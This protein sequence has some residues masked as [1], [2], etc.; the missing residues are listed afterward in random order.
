MA[1]SS[2]T[3]S[4]IEKTVAEVLEAALPGLRQQMAARVAEAFESAGSDGSSPTALLSAAATAIQEAGSQAEILRQLL[5]GSS[6]FAAR[7]ALF[8]VKSGAVNAWQSIGF[9][10]NEALKNA[11]VSAEKGLVAEAVSGRVPASGAAREFDAAFFKL[12]K[13]PARDECLVLPLVV[14][15]KVPALIYA[16]GGTEANGRFDASALSILTRF[17]ALWLEVG[18]RRPEPSGAGTMIPEPERAAAVASVPVASPTPAPAAPVPAAAAEA[19]HPAGDDPELHKK[20]KR[21]AKLLVEEIMLYNQ[22]KVAQGKKNQDLYTRL[23]EDIEKSRATYD[24]RYGGSVASTA[25]YFNQELVRILADND[26][27]LMGDGFPR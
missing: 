6:Q 27:S 20:A 8:V 7:A 19:A 21:F 14:K 26:V 23:R 2:E 13:S 15:D 9:D 4:I 18:T 25:D 24:K 3:R 12:A 1:R 22:A 17:A 11:S 16:D 10:D 5:E